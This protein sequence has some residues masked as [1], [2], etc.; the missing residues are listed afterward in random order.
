[1]A[2]KTRQLFW[3][4]VNEQDLHQC[5]RWV[6]DKEIPFQKKVSGKLSRN[7]LCSKWHYGYCGDALQI[8]KKKSVL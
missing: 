5:L 1:M 4:F 2:Y 7:G 3:M 6:S 8:F